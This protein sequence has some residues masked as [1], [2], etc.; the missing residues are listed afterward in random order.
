VK[1]REPGSVG[2]EELVERAQRGDRDAFGVLVERYKEKAYR[3][4]FDF[5]RDREEAKDISQEAFLRAY[6]H[7]KGFDMRSTFFTWFYRIVVNLCVDH[8]RRSGRAVWVSIEEGGTPDQPGAAAALAD[9][10]GLPEDRAGAE[11]LSRKA[12]AILDALP[13][14]QQTAFLLRNHE[15]L[16]IKEIAKIMGTAEGTVKAH[17]HRAVATLK[18][19]LLDESGSAR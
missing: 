18:R 17:L 3:I 2:D 10:S 1:N 7:L 14:K 11:E 15:G 9:G 5:V 6:V 4:A 19:G 13:P 12:T 16:P 8:R